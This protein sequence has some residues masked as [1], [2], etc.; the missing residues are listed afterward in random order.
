M[1]GSHWTWDSGLLCNRFGTCW[2]LLRHQ[3]RIYNISS[4]PLELL[5]RSPRLIQLSISILGFANAFEINSSEQ[6][7]LQQEYHSSL[8]SNF[9]FTQR[10]R[11]SVESPAPETLTHFN[12]AS[13]IK[14]FH[15]TSTHHIQPFLFP[16][17]P[18]LPVRLPTPPFSS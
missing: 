11:H 3:T 9:L 5:P 8:G 2:T 13:H 7:Q 1:L 17:T 18:Y 4:G 15:L 14:S 6:T 12:L 16:P 10:S